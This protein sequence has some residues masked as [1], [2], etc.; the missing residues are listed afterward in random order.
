LTE[1]VQTASATDLSGPMLRVAATLAGVDVGRPLVWLRWVAVVASLVTV[2]VVHHGL[3]ITLP[4]QQLYIVIAAFTAW[5][6]A[7]HLWQRRAGPPGALA[8]S[9]L[10]KGD[11]LA[12][13]AMLYFTG[14]W[15][16]PVV[17]LYL[18]P[19]AVSAA[20]LPARNA[21][22]V[23]L[24]CAAA[25]SCLT[26]WHVPLPSVQGRFGGDFN[27][28]IL[29]MWV[30]F[31]VASLLVAVFVATL[32]R[33]VRVSDRA[34]MRARERQLRDEHIVSL[35][36]LAAGAAHE[37]STPLTTLGLLVDELQADDRSADTE[38]VQLMRQQLDA[39]R[40]RLRLLRMHTDQLRSEAASRMRVSAF[41]EGTIERWRSARPDV[42]VTLERADGFVDAEVVVEETLAQAFAS[43]LNNAADASQASGVNRIAVLVES[44]NRK[45]SIAVSDW[46]TGLS[47]D[48]E[49]SLGHRFATTK[50]D[51]HG[52]GLVLSHAS[53]ERLGGTVCFASNAQGG[54]TATLEIP[55]SAMLL[56]NSASDPRRHGRKPSG[57]EETTTPE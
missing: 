19:V 47:A 36:T 2:L 42:L 11:V 20:V 24:T 35:G 5:S 43:I 48:I 30:N 44:D 14:G 15:T 54:S 40:D 51:G 17:S 12:L 10:L 34:L 6:L 3:S 32:A 9:A 27:L 49:A 7:I 57:T 1:Q 28:H 33:R 50:P 56:G 37:L 46:G 21:L 29:G 55:L 53:L 52:I 45:L 8:L 4:V 31:L 26:T 25:Y 38:R 16:N 22:A 18:V 41:I 13:T 39:M 23:A